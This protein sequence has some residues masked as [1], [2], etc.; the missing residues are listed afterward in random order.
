MRA[1]ARVCV[2]EH[3]NKNQSLAIRCGCGR[4]RALN[5]AKRNSVRISHK[6]LDVGRYC[7]AA[8]LLDL[9]R[10]GATYPGHAEPLLRERRA[11][12]ARV[13]AANE[14]TPHFSRDTTLRGTSFAALIISSRVFGRASVMAVEIAGFRP[15]FAG[16]WRAASLPRSGP[17]RVVSR[18]YFQNQP[19]E[20][21]RSN[22]A[23]V[24]AFKRDAGT[25]SIFRRFAIF[26]RRYNSFSLADR[27]TRKKIRGM[28]RV[29][30]QVPLYTIVLDTRRLWLFRR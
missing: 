3:S 23:P 11:A 18:V 2:C 4:E 16:S 25:R 24:R 8:P 30:G 28:G 21:A 1:R 20:R 13:I 17:V 10:R 12:V 26:T 6:V 5:K 22:G 9:H 14:R 27:R 19:N 7:S 29:I 15:D